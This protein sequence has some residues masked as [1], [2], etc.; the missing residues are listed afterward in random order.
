M[1]DKNAA[2]G[3]LPDRRRVRDHPLGLNSDGSISLYDPEGVSVGEIQA[4]WALDVNGPPVPTHYEARGTTSVQVSNTAPSTG[5]SISVGFGT[6]R[7]WC[8]GEQNRSRKPGVPTVS[9]LTT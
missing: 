4:P 6:Q 8:E 1:P 9:T 5:K 2:G 7:A 3:R